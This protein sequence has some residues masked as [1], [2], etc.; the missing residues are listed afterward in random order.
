MKS[1]SVNFMQP[2]V[3]LTA[4]SLKQS[5]KPAVKFLTIFVQRRPKLA[6][7]RPAESRQL[8]CPTRTLEEAPSGTTP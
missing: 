7:I 4:D 5:P 3:F 6:N 1:Q 2:Q 8:L